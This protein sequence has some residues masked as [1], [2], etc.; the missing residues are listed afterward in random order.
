MCGEDKVALP[1][2]LR[3]VWKQPF[4]GYNRLKWAFGPGRHSCSACTRSLLCD[5]PSRSPTTAVVLSPRSLPFERVTACSRPQKVPTQHTVV[6]TSVTISAQALTNEF[7][8]AH[9][10]TAAAGPPLIEGGARPPSEAEAG[11]AHALQ[12]ACSRSSLHSHVESGCVLDDTFGFGRSQ[13]R[14]VDACAEHS[15]EETKRSR[16]KRHP[17]SLT[18]RV[19]E[20]CGSK[21]R[22]TVNGM[23]RP[24]HGSIGCEGSSDSH[25][26]IP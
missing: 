25:S 16:S 17:C 8:N 1:V 14:L 9:S 11:T 15:P 3:A 26:C 21:H 10:A 7:G 6:I 2:L 19:H 20:Q 23:R 12:M 24:H 13:S 4:V 18:G 5:L 22:R